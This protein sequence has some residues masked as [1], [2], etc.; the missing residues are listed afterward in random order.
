MKQIESV[1]E[2]YWQRYKQAHP[3]EAETGYSHYYFCDN[4]QDAQALANLVI[5]GKKRATTSL[6]KTYENEGEALAKPGDCCIITDYYNQPQCIV[7]TTKVDLMPF[8]D[9]TEEYARIEGEGDG[10]LAY[11]RRGHVRYFS[12]ECE[13]MGIPF[14]EDLFVVCEQFEVIYR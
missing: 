14:T 12:K 9:V 2:R 7:R 4:E 10:S 3:Q 8:K 5:A 13:R 6:L 11:W 1:L